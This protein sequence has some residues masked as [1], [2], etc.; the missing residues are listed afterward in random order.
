MLQER[1]GLSAGQ[2]EVMMQKQKTINKIISKMGDTTDF[3]DARGSKDLGLSIE[4]QTQLTKMSLSKIVNNLR[5]KLKE[6][7]SKGKALQLKIQ[8]LTSEK[9]T[10]KNKMDTMK[11]E[12]K[13]V[14]SSSLLKDPKQ[15]ATRP[16]AAL[17]PQ[18]EEESSGPDL[19]KP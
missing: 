19:Q 4:E 8:Q 2:R 14:P 12:K 18:A 10:I 13:G 1:V 5:T 16:A 3:I 11:R 7:E 17:K 15:R 6:E 9:E